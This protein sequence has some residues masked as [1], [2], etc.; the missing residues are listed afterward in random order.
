MLQ[1]L[2]NLRELKKNYPDTNILF[3]R[4]KTPLGAFDE[5]DFDVDDLYR[6]G[7]LPI[8]Q[9]GHSTQL[10]PENGENTDEEVYSFNTRHDFGVKFMG[11][12]HKAEKKYN[13][14]PKLHRTLCDN[15][16]KFS[17]SKDK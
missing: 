16:G 7:L 3:I 2:D 10:S 12:N 11:K 5:P 17:K 1:E 13:M 15:L 8:K 9:K 4:V 14:S 6:Y